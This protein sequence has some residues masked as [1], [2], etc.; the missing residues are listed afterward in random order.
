MKILDFFDN[1]HSFVVGALFRLQQMRRRWRDSL[2]SGD[3]VIAFKPEAK[4]FHIFREQKR[5]AKFELFIGWVLGC[6]AFSDRA[7]AA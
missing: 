4:P 2:L 3:M 1:I 7:N 6:G 5:I